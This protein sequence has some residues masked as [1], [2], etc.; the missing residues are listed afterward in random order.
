MIYTPFS[1]SKKNHDKERKGK[2][3]E[4][5]IAIS[6]LRTGNLLHRA[7]SAREKCCGMKLEYLRLAVFILEYT[8]RVGARRTVV[9]AIIGLRI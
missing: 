6:C 7:R 4:S 2:K 3:K 8:S 1:E 9:A 5:C